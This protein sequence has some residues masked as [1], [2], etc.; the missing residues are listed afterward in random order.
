MQTDVTTHFVQ[1]DNCIV[2]I[3]NVPCSKCDQCGEISY[4]GT[5]ALRLEEIINQIER[6]LTEIAVVNY[7]AA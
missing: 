4:T 6:V 7:S 2:I 1:G 5:V 3:K